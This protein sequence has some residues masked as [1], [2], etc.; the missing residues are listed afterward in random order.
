MDKS[1]DAGHFFRG[2]A[3]ILRSLGEEATSDFPSTIS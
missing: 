3:T 1:V 2:G